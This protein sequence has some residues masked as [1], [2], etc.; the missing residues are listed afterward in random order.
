MT[1]PGQVQTFE[2]A[3]A[4]VHRLL[5]AQP[6]D[7]KISPF[8]SIGFGSFAGLPAK[9]AFDG[10]DGRSGSLIE[11][12]GYTGPDG[13]DWPVPEGAWLDG[14]SIPRPL[15]SIVGSPYTG[16]YLEASI[17]HDHYCII[18]TRG[19]QDTHRMFHDAMR[20]NGVGKFRASV[21]FYAVYRFGPRWAAVGLEA[22][23]EELPAEPLA[24]AKAEGFAADAETI[25]REDLDLD[26]IVALAERHGPE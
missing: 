17:V 25:V 8:E 22:M 7:A 12:L 23:L 3:T 4:Y 2:Q 9:V 15:W 21:M 10:G 19:W 1:Q 24:D 16:K 11:A 18:K 20:C 6:D 14:A 5:E 26:Q 13:T